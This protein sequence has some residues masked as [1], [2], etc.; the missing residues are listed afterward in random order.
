MPFEL[1]LYRP[2]GRPPVTIED[3][4][5]IATMIPH[6]AKDGPG[7]DTVQWRYK[8][9][10]TGVHFTLRYNPE[11]K[12]TNYVDWNDSPL[13]ISVAL[14]RPTFFGFEAAP[15][16]A[17]LMK[18]LNLGALDKQPSAIYR[19]PARLT[20]EQI[21]MSWEKSNQ[22]AVQAIVSSGKNVARASREKMDYFWRY[23][24]S[25]AALQES[26]GP[27]VLVPAMNLHKGRDGSVKTS[28][29][30]PDA[31]KVAL[32]EVDLVLVSREEK[33][34]LSKKKISG[35]VSYAK[36]S[37]MLKQRVEE[38]KEPVK[39]VLFN[40]IADKDLMENLSALTLEPPESFPK[41]SADDVVEA[42]MQK[43][44][45]QPLPKK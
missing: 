4:D 9:Q 38:K 28:C 2:R 7:G 6:F 45:S 3:V 13:S 33:K 44:A 21:R 27:D 26:L 29:I 43:P 24:S 18:D 1:I 32:P 15:V 23:M 30:W 17:R 16:I 14:S 12:N 31:A 5:R 41:V 20:E 35:A 40:K 19:Q 8:N 34:F 11:N 42:A 39:Y 25:R 37:A 22:A 36:I 10:E